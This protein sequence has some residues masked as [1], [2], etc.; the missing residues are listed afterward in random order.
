MI[1]IFSPING[2][3]K[4]LKKLNQSSFWEKGCLL[5]NACKGVEDLSLVAKQSLLRHVLPPPVEWLLHWDPNG[6]IR[7]HQ[8]PNLTCLGSC[9]K[10]GHL[11]L[12]KVHTNS[13]T[14]SSHDIC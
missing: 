11:S 14:Q 8:N 5:S 6:N 3:A 13:P 9:F 1:V 12:G 2:F 7:L 10:Y 4:S